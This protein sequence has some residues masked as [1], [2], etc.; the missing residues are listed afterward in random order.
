MTNLGKCKA[1]RLASK[2]SFLSDSDKAVQVH[3]Y[4]QLLQIRFD[5]Q[6]THEIV[7]LHSKIDSQNRAHNTASRVVD[8]VEGIAEVAVDFEGGT[9]GKAETAEKS[10]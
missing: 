10:R 3:L 1:I 9:T 7:R 6:R 2:R 5:Q 8:V 4:L